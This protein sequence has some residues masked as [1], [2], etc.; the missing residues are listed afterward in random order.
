MEYSSSRPYSW[1]CA[2]GMRFG[3]TLIKGIF[4]SALG[5]KGSMASF[6]KD[7]NGIRAWS[8][9]HRRIPVAP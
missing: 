2:F 5:K 3:L 1:A 4:G 6:R 8:D 7:G 9:R